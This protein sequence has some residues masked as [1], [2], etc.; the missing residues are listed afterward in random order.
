[1][2]VTFAHVVRAEWVRLRSLRSSWI[3]LGL[4]VLFVVGLGVLFTTVQVANW[5]PR[6]HTELLTFDPTLTSLGGTFLA[7]LAIGLLG[8][9]LVTG[10]YATGMI[11]A[12]FTAVPRRRSEE[13]TSELQS[14][15]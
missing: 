9:L 5:P 10:E 1:S 7:Q 14:R 3:T 4:T 15:S 13:H 8:V 11:R 6:D 2:R 12:T